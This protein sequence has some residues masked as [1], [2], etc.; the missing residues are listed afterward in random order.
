KR[1][2]KLDRGGVN[3]NIKNILMTNFLKLLNII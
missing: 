3:T 2:S 1:I